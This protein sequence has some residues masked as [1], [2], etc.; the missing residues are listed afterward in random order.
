MVKPCK[1]CGLKIRNDQYEWY[2]GIC[3]NCDSLANIYEVT[4]KSIKITKLTNDYNKGGL[5]EFEVKH[6]R[7]LY[8]VI[9][10]NKPMKQIVSYIDDPEMPMSIE[11]DL[12]TL[13]K[14]TN[15]LKR[16]KKESGR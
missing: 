7:T 15:F 5:W 12:P 9:Y 16:T 14:I 10:K 3:G 11:T 6:P 13:N 8:L 4:K 1:I 2:N